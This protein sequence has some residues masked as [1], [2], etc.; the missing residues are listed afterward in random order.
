MTSPVTVGKLEAVAGLKWDFVTQS[1]TRALRILAKSENAS[2]FIALPYEQGT[3]LGTATQASSKGRFVSLAMMVLPALRQRGENGIAIF[4]YADAYWFVAIIQG[5]LAVL[6]DV[7]GNANTVMAAV[8]EFE[9]FNTSEGGFCI[10]PDGFFTDRLAENVT[11]ADA[12]VSHDRLKN[13]RRF[14]GSRLLPVSTHKANAR[15]VLAGTLCLVSWFGW[16]QW[17]EL[18]AQEETEK[19]RQA[20]LAS[21]N[22][23]NVP[24]VTKPWVTKPLPATTLARCHQVWKTLP[25]SI[26]GWRLSSAECGLNAENRSILMTRYT[27]SDNGSVGDFALR[28]PAYFDVAPVF[29]IPGSASTAQFIL[30]V[31]M[32]VP[33]TAPE[34][35]LPAGDALVELTTYIQRL[36]ATIVIQ[37]QS[38]RSK[39]AADLPWQVY[40]FVVKTDIPPKHLFNPPVPGLRLTKIGFTLSQ[41]RLH[42]TLQGE[43]Y[44]R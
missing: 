3:L 33:K 36:Q 35:L 23:G 37:K 30:P 4:E 44:E 40:Q 39:T 42:Y 12:L 8:D 29:D 28:L 20:F 13:I 18:K 6:S 43:L 38:V 31:V 21:K 2:H 32:P 34:S 27:R 19:K 16:H 17:Q 25:L 22:K 41:G 26:A 9:R 7:T 10:A 24:L 5:N 11:L 14:W 1:K 15:R